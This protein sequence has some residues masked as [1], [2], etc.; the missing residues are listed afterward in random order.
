MRKRRKS[1]PKQK[2]HT[3]R[4]GAWSHKKASDKVS[5]ARAF[6]LIASLPDDFDLGDRNDPPQERK[7]L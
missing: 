1:A 4:K 5:L 7:G 3:K 2:P 6:Y